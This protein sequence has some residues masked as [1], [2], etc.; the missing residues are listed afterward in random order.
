MTAGFGKEETLY[1]MVEGLRRQM[2]QS[3]EETGTKSLIV[4]LG[5]IWNRTTW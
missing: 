3:W 4:P 2:I 1:L 5:I